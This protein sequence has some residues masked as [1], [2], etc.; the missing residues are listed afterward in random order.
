[1]V[2]A[3]DQHWKPRSRFERVNVVL[4][5]LIA[6]W[7]PVIFMLVVSYGILSK[8]LESRILRDRQSF[9]Q[10]IAHLVGDDLGRSCEIVNYYQTNPTV[11][12]IFTARY[13]DLAAKKWLQETYFAHPRIDGMFLTTADGRLLGSIPD[14]PRMLLQ[15]EVSKTWLESARG[16]NG[17][18]VSPVHPRSPDGR[19]AT[20]L[21]SAVHGPDGREIGFVGV[22]VLVERIGRRL[23]LINFADQAECQIIDQNGAILFGRDFNPNTAAVST[24]DHQ[25]FEKIRATKSGHVEEKKTIYSSAPVE[26]TGWLTVVMQPSAVAYQ[27]TRDLLWK[28]LGLAA[29][30]IFGTAIIAWLAGKFY[31]RQS[32]AAARIEREVVFTDK[33]L[34]NM[35]SGIALVD[36]ET[37][38]FLQ[39]NEAF[40]QMARRFGD[41][42]ADKEI[43]ES[44]YE[45]VNLAP[46][47]A[48]EKVLSFG[49]PF[50]LVEQPLVDRAG[51]TN[52][53]NVNLLRLQD[54]KQT[55]QGVLFLVEDK[56]RDVRLRQELISA[57]AAKD[58]F[59]ALLS[60]ELRNPLTPVIAMVGELEARAPEEEKL[61]QPLEVIRRNVELEARLIDDLLDVTRIAKGKL[62]LAFEVTSI[63][64]TLQRAYEICFEDIRQKNLQFEFR[65]HASHN[66][67]NGD[68]ARLQQ[69]F[70]NLI[71]NGVKFTPSGGRI[72]VQTSNPDPDHIEI[73]T[74]DSGIGIEQSKIEKIFNAFEQGQ[75]SI[76]RRFGGLGLG[77]AISKAMVRAHGGIIKVESDGLGQGAVF[78][79]ILNTVP[80][81]VE[82]PSTKA[83]VPA[84]NDRIPLEGRGHLLVVDDHHDTCIGMKMLLE[85]RG[86]RITLAHT[87]G[88]AIEQAQQQEFDLLISDI[89]LPDRS[90]YDL[91]RELRAKKSMRGIALSGYGMENDITKA[92]AAGFS[93][94]LTKPINF[95]RL[96]E[97]IRNLLVD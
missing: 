4:S 8:T 31:R 14:N 92:R 38:R 67:V 28:M 49:T 97:A 69:V 10:L 7:V 78:S 23:S 9:V 93:E 82:T 17:I 19:L 1:M 43:R 86:Y 65:L 24:T 11:A 36:P 35:P 62:Q 3:Q 87:A 56:T 57:N 39:A 73:R 41:L 37:R 61:R 96:D 91:M 45:E 81:P 27:P 54:S 55:V 72:I 53:V 90:G 75:T 95:D 79:V 26:S 47:D 64:E 6:G 94:H 71:K 52:F 50:Q 77:L 80:A 30:L 59:L 32:E 74:I 48:I 84:P 20:D 12:N 2:P 40:S 68:P 46:P 25:L 44:T 63:H 33:I 22:S 21:V 5:I 18:Y 60:H 88:Q 15:N 58:Q 34:A 70:W 29:W 16:K 13:P 42:G 83:P 89:G 76:T 85:R 66:Y 51:I